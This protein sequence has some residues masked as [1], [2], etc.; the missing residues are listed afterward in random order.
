ML[1]RIPFLIG[2]AAGNRVAAVKVSP[3][4]PASVA[5]KAAPAD[6]LRNR[7]LDSLRISLLSALPGTSPQSCGV[8]QSRA[9]IFGSYRPGWQSY[10]LRD[11][12]NTTRASP[13]SQKEAGGGQSYN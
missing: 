10:R 12:A 7:R 8:L 11:L 13:M 9:A 6:V 3:T 1:S 5:A 2:S 4:V